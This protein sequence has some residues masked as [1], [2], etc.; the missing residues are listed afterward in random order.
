M[1]SASPQLSHLKAACVSIFQATHTF[2]FAL[3]QSSSGSREPST[4]EPSPP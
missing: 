1:G 4:R 3:S 2:A